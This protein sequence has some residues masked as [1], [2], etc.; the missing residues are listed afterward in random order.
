MFSKLRRKKFFASENKKNYGA[1]WKSKKARD[2]NE[3]T[4]KLDNENNMFT[5]LNT[6]IYYT[7]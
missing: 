2:L 1:A 6:Y 7:Y 5:K 4:G 3:M